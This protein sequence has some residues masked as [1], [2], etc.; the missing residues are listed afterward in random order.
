MTK[1]LFGCEFCVV[2]QDTFNSYQAYEQINFYKKSLIYNW[3]K[4]GTFPPKI[5][6]IYFFNQHSQS[7]YDVLQKKIENLE[8]V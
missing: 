7:L 8:F 3:L 2:Q 6:K 4:N 5:D 1:P